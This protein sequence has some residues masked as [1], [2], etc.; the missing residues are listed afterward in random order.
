MQTSAI[1]LT[2]IS[3]SILACACLITTGTYAGYG[4]FESTVGM[5]AFCINTDGDVVPCP[6][7]TSLVEPWLYLS[8]VGAPNNQR[9]HD[10]NFGNITSL[11]LHNWYF[12]NYA[13]N[14]GYANNWLD[15]FSTATLKVS[16]CGFPCPLPGMPT[17]SD[18]TGATEISTNYYALKQT[19]IQFNNRTWDLSTGLNT[20][21]AAG[22][23]S[24][25]YTVSFDV[26]YTYNIWLGSQLVDGQVIGSDSTGPSIANFY[27]PAPGVFTLLGL[28]G[29]IGTRRRN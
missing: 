9:L 17:F 18:S 15:A 11:T 5:T 21:L 10:Y 28:A 12:E 26:T 29:V 1:K 16:I 2:S 19:G 8:A 6:E 27:I 3:S 14:D 7:S 20:D 24:G 22:L 13:Y 23:A 25:N 4:V